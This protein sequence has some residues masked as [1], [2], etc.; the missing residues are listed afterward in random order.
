VVFTAHSDSSSKTEKILADVG[1]TRGSETVTEGSMHVSIRETPTMGYVSGNSSGLTLLFGMSAADAKK[2]GRAWESWK[3]GTKQ[4]SILKEDL[5]MTSVTALLPKA[6]GTSST[7][8]SS[9]TTK[10]FV[11]RWTSPATTSVPKLSNT[12][13]ISASGATLPITQTSTAKGG[14][15]VTTVLSKWGETV[16]VQPPPITATIS[17]SKI[18]G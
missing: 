1:K 7:T 10:L 11:L 2:V 8:T 5:T 4:F 9:G 3:A 17:S 12:I 6:E 18:T 15:K 13:T 16:L 14:T